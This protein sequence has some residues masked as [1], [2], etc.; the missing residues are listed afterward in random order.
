MVT[1]VYIR[2][3]RWS[4]RGF[5][6]NLLDTLAGAGAVTGSA[7]ID[8]TYVKAQRSTFGGMDLLW[9][10]GEFSHEG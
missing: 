7:A 6:L 2:F 8:S 10:N 5:L 1:T 3:N 4:A 9:E